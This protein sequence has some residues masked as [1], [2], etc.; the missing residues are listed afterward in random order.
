LHDGIFENVGMPTGSYDS[1]NK[2][3][4]DTLYHTAFSSSNSFVGLIDT[5]KSF[6]Q[7]RILFESSASITDSSNLLFQNNNLLNVIGSISATDHIYIGSSS[8]YE[9]SSDTI[10][11]DNSL[12]INK[13]FGLDSTLAPV[14]GETGTLKMYYSSSGSSPNRT[15][16]LLT[17]SENNEEI[18]V[19]SRIV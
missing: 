11:T 19:L 4:V 8:F 16:S 3:Y 14:T 13:I 9:V 2:L 12:T 1:A 17:K 18:V 7:G 15:I 10:K 5:P 6:N